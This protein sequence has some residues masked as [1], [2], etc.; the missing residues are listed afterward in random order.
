L[1]E[2]SDRRSDAL[3][4]EHN[5]YLVLVAKENGEAAAGRTYGTDVYFDNGL[6]HKGYFQR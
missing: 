5:E 6:T 1:H 4:D 2:Q 3:I